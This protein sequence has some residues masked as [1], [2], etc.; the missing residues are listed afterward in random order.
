MNRPSLNLSEEC[1]YKA[2]ILYQGSNDRQSNIGAC[3]N[4]S[5][6]PSIN[7]T[8]EANAALIQAAISAKC[9]DDARP[10]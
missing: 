7:P 9:Y 3:N 8:D 5:S 6:P 4:T 1:S 2:L 10:K